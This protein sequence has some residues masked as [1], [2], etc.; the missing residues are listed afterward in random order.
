[1]RVSFNPPFKK[2]APDQSGINMVDL[3]MWLVIAA[4]LLATAIQSIG[5][6][7][8]ASWAYQAQND[9]N[10]AQSWV[11][12][13]IANEGSIPTIDDMN[14]AI[15][16]GDLKMTKNGS[17]SNIG[18]ISI[19]G[20]K[21]CVGVQSSTLT[22]SNVFYSSSDAPSNIY[23]DTAIPAACGTTS[24]STAT[25]TATVT[26]SPTS[27]ATTPP[28][29]TFSIALTGQGTSGQLGN[30]TL[31]KT[32]SAGPIDMT[33]V[34]AGK[35]IK[36][37]SA[38]SAT[39]C[40]IASD[41][42]A[43]CW[44]YGSYGTLG[45]GGTANSATPVAVGGILAGKTLVSIHAGSSPCALDDA[46][47]VYCWGYGHNGEI[48]NGVYADTN[49]LPAAITMT[50]AL[51]GKTVKSLGTGNGSTNCVIGSDDL[52]YCWGGNGN[53]AL[54]DGTTNNT[55]SPKLINFGA[56]AGKKV[57]S[58]VSTGTTC[59]VDT[60]GAAYCWGLNSNGTVGDNSTVDRHSPVA[61]FATGAL[62]G[63][64]ITSISSGGSSSCA[65]DSAGKAY[66]WGSNNGGAL[67]STSIGGVYQT[68][69]TVDT[70]G[71]LAG[72]SLVSISTGGMTTCGVTSDGGAY[73]WG[74]NGEGEAGD[75]TFALQHSFPVA[76]SSLAG[77][78]A[79][80]AVSGSSF[81]AFLIQQ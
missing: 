51:A 30:G 65:L 12:A 13:R 67:G 43:Y 28:P 72:K 56:L 52:L 61:V 50:G 9:V 79:K 39:T 8:K 19:S 76:V 81:T 46:G 75:T 47:V 48:G 64:T 5:Y 20:S 22:G 77:K 3:M 33:G 34:L 68:P 70:S 59:A 11:A 74:Y 24:T 78:I 27:T 37:I 18:L 80:D 31:V 38:G 73:C 7:Q 29:A 62:A 35:T 6:Y 63:K 42:K 57:K 10:H 58:V 25:A 26:A 45:N 32:A 40:V 14:A 2:H 23:Q 1:M 55:P 69:Q 15:A 71:V 66:C 53:G 60:N 36:S 17:A 4:L 41:S 16:S 21:Y 54:G 44:G 49:T